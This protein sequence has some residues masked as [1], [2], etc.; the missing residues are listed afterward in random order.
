MRLK[1]QLRETLPEGMVVEWT[2]LVY[3]EKQA[4]NSAL[5]IFALA[6]LLALQ[7]R[8]STTVGRFALRRPAYCAYVITLS[9][10][11]RVVSGGDNNLF[12]S[13][14]RGAGR[15]GVERHFDC[16]VA[17]AKEHGADS[18]RRTGSVPAVLRPTIL[19]TSFAF[20][21]GVVPLVLPRRVP[22][23]KCDMRW[24]SPCLRAACWAS[25]FAGLD[26]PACVLR[27]GSQDGIKA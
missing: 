15:H 5:A 27:G 19:M 24:A 2:D 17:R 7:S 21:A 10:C 25:R 23:L 16:R 22:A 20:I 11:R 1:R 14:F 6:V 4:G 13:W 12:C 8:R 26:R 18:D 9:H 3:Q